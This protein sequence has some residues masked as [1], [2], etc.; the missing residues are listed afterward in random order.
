MARLLSA[1]AVTL[2]TLTAT[3]SYAGD[4]AISFEWGNIK[5][6]TSGRPNTVPN[7]IFQLE[8]VPEGTTWI[9]FKMDDKDAPSYNHGGGWV[10]YTGQTKI[11]PGVFKYESPCPPGGQHNYEWTATAK[12]KKSSWGGTIGKAKASKMYP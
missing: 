10:E 6:C 9:Y 1:L 7:P 8:N 5:K 11:E 4:F 3:V 2:I 12:K